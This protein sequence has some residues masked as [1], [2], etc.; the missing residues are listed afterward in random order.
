MKT[1]VLLAGDHSDVREVLSR[2]LQALGYEVAVA[3]NGMEAVAM[4]RCER[5]DVILMD[6]L[7]PEMD[8]LEAV[9]KIRQRPELRSIPVLAVTAWA[10]HGSRKKYLAGGFNDY[11]PKP[12]THKELQNA[13]EKLLNGSKE[14]SETA[15]FPGGDRDDPELR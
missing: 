9:Y 3:K 15:D 1:R 6:I 2:Q 12:F 7:M 4:A 14:K 8:G 13:I 11:I 5:P 10:S